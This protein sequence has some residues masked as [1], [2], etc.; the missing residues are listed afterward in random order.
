[1]KYR[2][3]LKL[4]KDSSG[5]NTYNPAT[6]Q[7]YSYNWWR[8]VDRVKGKIV[9]N[10]FS[11]S[12]TTNKHQWD[13]KSLLKELGVKIDYFLNV[14]RG[15][16]SVTKD[17][18]LKLIFEAYLTDIK[19][20]RSHKYKK[21]HV[22]EIPNIIKAA[23]LYGIKITKQDLAKTKKLAL[24]DDEN[25]RLK[26]RIEAK[27]YRDNLKAVKAKFQTELNSTDAISI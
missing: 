25:R 3:R 10:D 14:P 20:E 21:T 22:S 12:K 19:A 26:A 18:V 16:Q 13:A 6:G 11:Y 27:V 17:S 1:M 9:F 7:A 15:L 24:L 23:K 8:Y 4:Y 5:N 2:P